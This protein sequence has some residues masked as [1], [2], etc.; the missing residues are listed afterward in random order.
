MRS[1]W[2]SRDR[3]DGG[4][5]L[6]EVLVAFT[7][8]V[9][10]IAAIGYGMVQTTS[11]GVDAT[12][13]SSE[14][15]L[16]NQAIVQAEALPFG[17]VQ[18]GANAAQLAAG[19]NHAGSAL[20]DWPQV[21]YSGTAYTLTLNP[22]SNPVFVG[23][24][25]TT[26]PATAGEAPLAPF[27]STHTL[28]NVKYKVAVFV[29]AV[30]GHPTLDLVRVTAIVERTLASSTTDPTCPP[31]PTTCP[32]VTTTTVGVVAQQVELGAQ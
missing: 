20:L 13:M 16:A 26:N 2:N 29:T 9:G 23:N 3:G 28:G 27:V 11:A 5:A 21:T 30:T 17:A 4:Q 1:H 15:T 10:A 18:S 22:G 25:P 19:L 6:L 8:L 31:L 12:Q 14:T 24:V 7:I 32:P